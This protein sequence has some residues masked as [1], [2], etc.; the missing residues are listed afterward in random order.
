[1]PRQLR[2]EYE[3]AIYHVMNRGDHGENIFF[4]DHDRETFLKILGAACVKADW[5]VHAFCLMKNHFHLVLETPKPTLVAGMKW[6]MGVYTQRFN[7]RH[8]KHG[9]LFA[10]RYKSLIVDGSESYYLRKV[11]DYV[12]LN[13]AKAGLI[14]K[15]EF[16]EDYRWSSFRG[17]LQP[18]CH[19]FPWLRVDRLLGEYG[20]QEDNAVGRRKL[21]RLMNQRCHEN[22]KL[23]DLTDQFI[24]RN[25]KLGTK[26]FLERLQEKII[27]LPK[28]ENHISAECNETVKELG[29]RLIREKLKELKIK[30][31]ILKSLPLTHPAK[32][33][34]A[35]FLREQ[36]TLPIKWIA[37]E[38]NAGNPRTL[39]VALYRNKK[40]LLN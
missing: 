18:P 11:C 33:K 25:W 6:L 12:H 15:G 39:A 22:E 13:P 24:G 19:R 32:I 16:L 21:S 37:H 3:G 40:A 35:A 31:T 7:I 36:T 9:H 2:I 20:I 38:I 1:M 30:P 14:G 28:K 17:Y 29:R 26:D 10:G 23:D 34:I 4:D 8:Q 5:Q 27:A